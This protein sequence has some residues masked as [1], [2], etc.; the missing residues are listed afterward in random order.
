[1]N[2]YTRPIKRSRAKKT[3]SNYLTRRQV[4]A[5][6]LKQIETKQSYNYSS[7][8]AISYSGSAFELFPNAQGDTDQTVIG[9]RITPVYVQVKYGLDLGDTTNVVT[10]C[11]IQWKGQV[12][13]DPPLGSDVFSFTGNITAPFSSWDF[14]EKPNFRVLAVATHALDTYHPKAIGEFKIPSY[15][16]R[17]IYYQENDIGNFPKDGGL[18]LIAISD[19][20][21][22]T[23]PALQFYANIHY[24]DA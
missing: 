21:A 9:N 23:H 7:A 14:T 13:H 11:V 2:S 1:M 10:L 20:G 4:K 5:E 15:K 3:Y 24:K 18:Y 22:V 8:D 19:S 16:L 12:P 6:V 17:P